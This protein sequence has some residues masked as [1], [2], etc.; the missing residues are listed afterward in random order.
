MQAHQVV[1][2]VAKE[3]AV[4]WVDYFVV[5]AGQFAEDFALGGQDAAHGEQDALE[6]EDSFKGVGRGLNKDFILH[7][8]DLV[9]YGFDDGHIVCKQVVDD[10]IEQVLGII[11]GITFVPRAGVS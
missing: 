1:V 9:V 8:I 3:D 6:R 5:I 11:G 2:D 7:A 10:F 4:F